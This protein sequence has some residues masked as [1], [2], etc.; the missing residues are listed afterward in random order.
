MFR[1]LFLFLFFLFFL[2]CRVFTLC[3]VLFYAGEERRYRARALEGEGRF[4]GGTSTSSGGLDV[5]P[6]LLFIYF[7]FYFPLSLCMVR[8]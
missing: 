4:A 1:S 7:S 3:F 8:A 6:M 5:D 2:S